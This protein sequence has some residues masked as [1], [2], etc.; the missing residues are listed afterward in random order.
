[1]IYNSK[2]T[3]GYK[4]FDYLEYSSKSCRMY[5]TQKS[6][7]I[8]IPFFDIKGLVGYGFVTTESET[9]SVKYYIN[10]KILNYIK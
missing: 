8:R 2:N 3:I 9:E 1:M 7:E 6:C 10:E 5:N 4:D